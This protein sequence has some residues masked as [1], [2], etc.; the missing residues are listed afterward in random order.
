MKRIFVI[1]LTAAMATVVIHTL[2]AQQHAEHRVPPAK[3]GAG[4][5][6]T[7][8]PVVFCPTM[9]TGQLCSEGTTAAL[10]LTGDKQAAWVAAVRRYNRTVNEATMQLQ[11]EAKDTLSSVQ[12]AE[13]QRWFAIG[14]NPQIN[15]LLVAPSKANG[16]Q[17]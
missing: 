3:P 1:A 13:V 15:Q 17:K 5:P 14:M 8:A 2:Y 7:P 9:K 10:G 16:S 11:T 6:A 12:M 4:A